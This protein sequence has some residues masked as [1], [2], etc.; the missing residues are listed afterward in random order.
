MAF[1][2]DVKIV[3]LMMAIPVS[4][5]NEEWY[6]QFKPLLMDEESRQ[7]FK[8]P[9]QYMFKD[10]P[11]LKAS[12]DY[13][14]FLVERMD[15]YGIEVALVGY[16]DGS[17]AAAAA[18]RDLSAAL[19][20]RLPGEPQS[21]HGGSA[22]GAAHPRRVR[23]QFGERLSL[24]AQPAGADQRQEDVPACTPRAWSWACPFLL[25]SGFRVRGCRSTR[26]RSSTSTRCAGSSR[27]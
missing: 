2:R 13:V 24:W 27:S 4:E 23:H 19:H 3:D 14:H 18:K 11:Q 17:A 15:R 22:P 20:L 25:M 7:Q 16:F 21:R 6:Q 1:P 12:G 5:T 9:A 10:I 26:R 8:M